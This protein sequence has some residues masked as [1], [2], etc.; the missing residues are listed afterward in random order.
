MGFFLD[1]QNAISSINPASLG[2][3]TSA[4]AAPASQPYYGQL[5]FNTFFDKLNGYGA[6]AP[7]QGNTLFGNSFG[8]NKM[9]FNDYMRSLIAGGPG[10]SAPAVPAAAPVTG[11]GTNIPAN[12]QEW[13][14]QGYFGANPNAGVLSLM[15]NYQPYQALQRIAPGF[16]SPHGYSSEY[17]RLMNILYPTIDNQAQ[18]GD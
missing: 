9:Q 2:L 10:Y 3:P 5:P 8:P 16:T 1:I 4:P 7:A 11:T 12:L 18:G 15:S 6:G 17:E 14:D 13:A